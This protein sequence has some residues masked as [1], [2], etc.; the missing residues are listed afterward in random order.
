MYNHYMRPFKHTA[1]AGMI[2]YQGESDFISGSYETYVDRFSALVEYMRQNSNLTNKNFP[3]FVTELPSMFNGTEE[4]WA[5]LPTAAVRAAMGLIP[6]A[7]DN[8]Y[9]A[10]TSDIWKDR[11]HKNN[12]HPYCKYYI[13]KRLSALAGSVIYDGGGLNMT[14]G[15]QIKGYRLSEDK[16]SVTL[17][18]DYVGKGL[19][20]FENGIIKGF[21]LNN[22]TSPLSTE[23]TGYNSVTLT[24]DEQI[25]QVKYN[26]PSSVYNPGIW[27]AATEN[28]FPETVNMCSSAGIPMISFSTAVSE[29]GQMTVFSVGDVNADGEISV[30]DA[31]LVLQSSV[32]KIGLEKEQKS[33]ADANLDGFVT[34]TDA[35]LILQA[36]VNKV[37]I[38]KV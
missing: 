25:T 27:Y 20:S 2:W 28:T 14:A 34:V 33:L 24:S 12:L 6:T 19:M 37:S 21:L 16:K 36:S 13:A 26:A 38:P 30:T 11:E 4:G 35:L 17:Y 8:T 9:M 10:A 22:N 29:K 3:V 23:I 7:V 32:G 31:L 18:F 5:F 1:I 15:P